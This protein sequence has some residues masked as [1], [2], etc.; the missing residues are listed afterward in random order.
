MSFAAS[1]L[2]PSTQGRSTFTRRRALGALLALPALGL[3][4][5]CGGS[6]TA[7]ATQAAQATSPLATTV[8]AGTTITVG[9]PSVKVALE[10]SGLI[11][12]LDFKVEFANISGGPQTTEAFR[13]NAL[14]VGSVADIPPIHA[15]WTGLDV[16]IVASAVPAGRREPPALRAGHRA[17]RRNLLAAGPARQE[18]RLQPGP[19]PGRAGAADP[20]EGRPDQGAT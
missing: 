17:R 2:P 12:E 10:L 20:G 3:L 1:F 6:A 9:D 4:T 8:P 18:D 5:A 13:A 19:G 16:R 11:K 15:T 14:D 7:G